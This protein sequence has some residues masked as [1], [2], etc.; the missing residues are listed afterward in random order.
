M[1][2]PP[3]VILGLINAGNDIP[4]IAVFIPSCKSIVRGCGALQFRQICIN[5]FLSYPFIKLSYEGVTNDTYSFKE[6]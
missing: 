2:L 4:T 1:P 3:V 6:F 5:L